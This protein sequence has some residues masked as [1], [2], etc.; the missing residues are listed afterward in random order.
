MK[1][2]A[3]IKAHNLQCVGCVIPIGYYVRSP[4]IYLSVAFGFLPGKEVKEAKIGN[5]GLQDR[6]FTYYWHS[7]CNTYLLYFKS[8][9]H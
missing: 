8:V 3:G 7:F 2:A 4:D 5:L 1:N 6:E 9:S